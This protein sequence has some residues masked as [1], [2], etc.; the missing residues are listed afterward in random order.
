MAHPNKVNLFT[1]EQVNELDRRR[2]M[3]ITNQVASID[4]LLEGDATYDSEMKKLHEDLAD[5]QQREELLQRRVAELEAELAEH[6][7][8]EG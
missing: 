8:R 4:R 5:S 3:Q 6:G 7:P 2:Q 1:E